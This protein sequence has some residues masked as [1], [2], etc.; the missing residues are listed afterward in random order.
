M[1]QAEIVNSTPD[2][3]HLDIQHISGD[4]VDYIDPGEF[5][6]K[7]GARRNVPVSHR[8]KEI[9]GRRMKG[10][11]AED[12]IFTKIDRKGNRVPCK[13]ADIQYR[14]K[15]VCEKAKIPYGD[16]TLN[17]KG[18]RIGIVFHC[19][20]HTRTSKW[21]QLGYSDEIIRCATGH[22][23][24]AAFQAYVKLDPHTIMRLVKEKNEPDSTINLQ[25]CVKTV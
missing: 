6:T 17:K 16:K 18:E 21:V 12:K 23:T 25:K 10:L 11:G 19:L 4:K 9:P 1:R 5:D 14:L 2:Q 13:P 3:V 8:V 15:S 20:R 22:K 7:T 24:L